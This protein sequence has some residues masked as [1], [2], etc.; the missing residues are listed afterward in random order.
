MVTSAPLLVN[1]K[2]ARTSEG[3]KKFSI[4]HYHQLLSQYIPNI[5]RIEKLTVLTIYLPLINLFI[6]RKL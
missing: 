5:F 3:G 6:R 2:L 1:A 4:D